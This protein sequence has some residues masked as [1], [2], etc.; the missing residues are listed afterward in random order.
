MENEFLDKVED[1]AVVRMWSEKMQ[2]E[3]GDSLA[4]R[5][6][7]ELWDFTRIS[8]TQNEFQELRDI[9][10]RW[11]DKTKHCFTFG[12]V[13]LV[14]TMEEYTALLYYPKWVTARIQQKGDGICKPWVSLRNLIVA[15]P[16][17]KKKIDVF[18]LSI[19]GLVIFPKAL[20][21]IDE[22]VTDLFNQL[23]KRV[24][25]I[26]TILAETFR[27]LSAC[28][29]AG[30]G[31]FIGYAQLLLAWF[32]SHFWNLDK[33]SY[34]VFSENYSEVDVEWRALWLVPDEI[35]YRCGSFD[36]VPL[37]GIWGAVGYAPLLGDNY[38]KK[39]LEISNAWKQTRWMK[40]LAISLMTTPEYNGW[41][42][43]RINDNISG[44]SLEGKLEAAKFKK[45]KRKV[46][47][48][49]DSLKIDYKK[50]QEKARADQ[51][52]KR[53][54]DA[55]AREN[56][57]KKSLIEGQDEREILVARVAELE[58]VLHQH[59]DRNSDIELRASLS[60]IEDLKGKV[61]ELETTLQNCEL[62]IE[63]LDSNN[64]QWK[65]QLRQ[66]QDQVR[67]RDYVMGE[68]VAQI[69]EVVDH[70]QTLAVQAD[71]L[72]VKYELESDRGRELA[73][74]LKRV[75]TL[76]IKAKPYL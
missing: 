64:E 53:F 13:D 10:A 9:W 45:R 20:R 42:S 35:L 39:V 71:V 26:P 18:A 73:C 60:R 50:L 70:L 7:S 21:H 56:A 44:P 19:Y 69:R 62:R 17:I 68:A 41:L 51:W 75:K 31:R 43:K 59:R 55:R 25:P 24:T 72:S 11:D 40:R 49:L 65:I 4:K 29:R 8:V 12:N 1:N 16:D 52:E 30:E 6:M 46:E 76:S 37:L 5:Y 33:I 2:L 23:N 74:L 47:E 48:D 38:K 54:H 32:H 61:E 28:R 66:L 36:W 14:P 3:K 57:L 34:R 67:D 22:A 58:K 15:Y 27:F 63:F